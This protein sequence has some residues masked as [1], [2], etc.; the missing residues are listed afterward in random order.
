MLWKWH[1]YTK[2]ACNRKG[3]DGEWWDENRL[4]MPKKPPP[5]YWAQVRAQRLSQGRVS[6]LNLDTHPKVHLEFAFCNMVREKQS[7]KHSFFVCGWELEGRQCCTKNNKKKMFLCIWLWLSH[8]HTHK[9]TWP[10]FALPGSHSHH[11]IIPAG[12]RDDVVVCW[13]LTFGLL[14]SC[15]LL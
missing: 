10:T 6:D 8:P 1:F 7:W 4:V 12:E 2:G 14:C 3:A 15:S 5:W 13:A 9:Y 11:C